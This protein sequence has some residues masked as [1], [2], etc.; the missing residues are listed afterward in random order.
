MRALPS[1]ENLPDLRTD[2]G[3][4]ELIRRSYAAVRLYSLASGL[5][6]SFELSEFQT[7]QHIDF[8]RFR[9]FDLVTA[10]GGQV[11][12]VTGHTSHGVDGRAH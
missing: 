3:K 9:W 2:Q 4:E 8:G 10:P 1:L 6:P 12:Q 11:I 7:I 5:H